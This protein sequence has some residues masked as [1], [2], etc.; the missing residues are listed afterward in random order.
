MGWS[1]TFVESSP[2]EEKIE[3]FLLVLKSTWIKRIIRILIKKKE[4]KKKNNKDV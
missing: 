1:W 4:K 3:V 2:R